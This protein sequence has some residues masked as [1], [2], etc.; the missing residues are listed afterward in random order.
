MRDGSDAIADWPILNA[1]VNVAA[2]ATWVSVHHGGG[3]GIGNSIHAGM[4]VVADGTDE[5][6]ERLERVLTADPGLGVMRHL[7][8]GYEDA[9]EAAAEHGLEPPMAAADGNDAERRR[10]RACFSATSTRWRPRR[11]RCAAARH[12]PRGRRGGR[13]RL[14][15]DRG[16]DNRRR[17]PNGGPRRTRRRPGRGGRPRPLRDPGARRLPH[18]S[19]VRR[20]P[21]RGVLA[22]R[23]RR[24]VRGAPRRGRRHPRDRPCHPRGRRGRS[25]RGRA[26]ASG[27]DAAR[28]HDDVGGQV[29]LRP[30]PRHRARVAAGGPR[31]RRHPD[32]ARR[33]RG[34]AG[35]RRRRRVPRLRARRGAAG[36]GG[37]GRGCRRLPRAGRVRRTSGAPL[38]RGVPRRRARSAPARRPVHRGRCDPAGDRARRPFRRP[39]RGHGARR[40]PHARRLRR[41]RGP[42]ARERALPRPADAAGREP[43]RRGSRRRA[44]DR[45]QS[46]QR[47][48]RE[49]AARLRARGDAARLVA[50]RGARRLHGE[51]RPRARSRRR[52]RAARAGVPTRTACSS[53]RPTGATSPTTSAAASCTPSSSAARW[54]GYARRM[55]TKKQQRRRAKQR[56]HEYEEAYYDADGN[57]ISAEEYEQLTGEKVAPAAAKN[58]ASKPDR[59]IQ[60]RGGR[61]INPPSWNRVLKRAAIFAPIMFIVVMLVSPEGS[62][63]AGTVAQTAFL[64]AHLPAV[65]L[66]DGHGD[67]PHVA[68]PH[69]PDRQS[70]ADRALVRPLPARAP[71]PGSGRRPATARAGAGCLAPPSLAT[72]VPLVGLEA[73]ERA[74]RRPRSPRRRSP[75]ARRPSTTVIQARSLTWWSPRLWPG[76]E[77][78]QDCACL[79]VASGGRPDRACRRARRSRGG[80][81][82]STPAP[83]PSAGERRYTRTPVA[84]VVDRYEL[85]PMGTNCYVVRAGARGPEA[86]VVDPGGDAAQLRLEL[87]GSG[88]RCAAI[89][90][91]H[92]HWDHLGGVADLAEGTGA[93]V[94]MSAVEAPCARAAGGVVSGRRDP[95]VRAGRPPARATRSSRSPASSSRRSPCPGTPRAT[96]PST[97]T[98]RSS[99]ATCS[100]QAPSVARI[101][102]SATGTR[103][104][105]SIRTLIGALPARDRRLPGTRAADDARRRARAQP[106]PRR[107]ARVVTRFEAP[108]GTHDILPSERPAWRHVLARHGGAVRARTATAGSQ[109]PVFEDTELFAAHVRPGLRRRP[110]GDVHVRGPRRTVA[111]AA[112]RGDGADLP[113]VPPARASSGRACRR[114]CTR[115]RPC[116]ATA[117]PSAGATAST[118]RCRSRR[119]APTTRRSTPS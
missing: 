8:A 21:R 36:G 75:C 55:A 81:S 47:V 113:R 56:R 20:R 27:V 46:G 84:P 1:L 86:V 74:G 77:A 54:S 100:S 10:G 94:Y 116:T 97:R 64:H 48:L 104:V 57:E 114:S 66:R 65:Q 43:G 102:R 68:A 16:R 67:L 61:T 118:G 49:P 5:M 12:R 37:A 82:A 53:T 52:R 111:D 42:A 7:D 28:G 33:A 60:A 70:E 25:R 44:R 105:G 40:H 2:G 31:R 110:E 109:T 108:R 112:S 19:G 3:V 83:D 58:G 23:R 22:P 91:T 29:G 30:R 45:L 14:R 93:P 63:I 107:A 119:S 35:V 101:C 62:S 98:A 59:P 72:A 87:A 115:S 69:R 96:S 4:V 71:R 79:L 78:D 39:P 80:S 34:P 26:A 41:H 92:S 17:R 50:G 6:A 51:C 106:V 85:G 90:I 117:R 15:A 99:P 76:V 88:A 89:L 18:A 103:C 9:R 32:L 95:A 13:A 11:A 24:V 73:D 38:P